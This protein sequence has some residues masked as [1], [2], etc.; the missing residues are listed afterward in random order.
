MSSQLSTNDPGRTILRQP[1]RP[2][3]LGFA[4]SILVL[5]IYCGF[6][7]LVGYD[8]PL[9]GREIIPGLSWGVLLGALVIVSAWV[10][11][12]VYV[13]ASNRQSTEK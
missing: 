10:L 3:A 8:K 9:L 7:L 6:V 2:K 13:A 11:T 1:P 12:F 4:L 5:A